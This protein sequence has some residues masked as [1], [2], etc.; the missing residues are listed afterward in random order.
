MSSL[1]ELVQYC[2]QRTRRAEFKDAPGAFNGLQLAN[3]GTV[4][5]IGAAR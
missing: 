2:D 5:K 4:T 1:S 3:R